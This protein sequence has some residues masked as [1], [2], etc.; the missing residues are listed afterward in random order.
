M[1]PVRVGRERVRGWQVRVRW[2]MWW[3][4]TTRQGAAVFRH[5]GVPGPA[6]GV[7]GVCSWAAR[8]EKMPAE[9]ATEEAE[10]RLSDS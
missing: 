2:G 3:N 5:G 7:A 4:Q 1:G 9:G 10:S 8:L 6:R